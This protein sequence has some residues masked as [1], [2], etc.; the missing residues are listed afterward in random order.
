VKNILVWTTVWV[1]VALTLVGIVGW[2]ID[3]TKDN[4]RET[5]DRYAAEVT[6]TGGGHFLCVRDGVIVG[7]S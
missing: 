4:Q 6:R 7:G 1:A 2:A 5:C 3:W